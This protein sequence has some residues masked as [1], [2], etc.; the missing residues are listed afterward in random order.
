MNTTNEIDPATYPGKWISSTTL[1]QKSSRAILLKYGDRNIPDK[2]IHYLRRLTNS[3]YWKKTTDGVHG[4]MERRDTDASLRTIARHVVCSVNTLL[5]H[6]Q[7]AEDLGLVTIN[8]LPDGSITHSLHLDPMLKWLPSKECEK[9]E[10]EAD[11]NHRSW[12]KRAQRHQQRMK[13][14]VEY[15]MLHTSPAEFF[16]GV[17]EVA[18][19]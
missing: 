3:C 4:F 7:I 5:H 13:T 8:H 9:V 2:T 6:M 18:N 15:A 10:E 12:H 17:E 1:D 16:A 19:D 11:R 14:D